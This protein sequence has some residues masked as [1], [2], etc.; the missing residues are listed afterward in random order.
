MEKLNIECDHQ[1]GPE[2]HCEVCCQGNCQMHEV[3]FRL[4][5]NGI[6]FTGRADGSRLQENWRFEK[7]AAPG[8]PQ[9]VKRLTLTLD[10]RGDVSGK[11]IRK[12]EKPRK[13]GIKRK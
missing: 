7:P 8:H 3:R 12:G 2:Y 13:F 10:L 9:A 1:G 11:V 4:E 6:V 5:V